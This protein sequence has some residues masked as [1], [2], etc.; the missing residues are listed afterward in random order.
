MFISAEQEVQE[1]QGL[2]NPTTVL[3]PKDYKTSVRNRLFGISTK[4]YK[5]CNTMWPIPLKQQ[6]EQLI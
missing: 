1:S 2:P 3:P 5:K 6:R 4:H